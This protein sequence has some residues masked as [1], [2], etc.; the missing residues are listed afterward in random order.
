MSKSKPQTI[1]D[2]KINWT[3]DWNI[4]SLI[5]AKIEEANPEIKHLKIVKNKYNFVINEWDFTVQ[6]IDNDTLSSLL[7][8][9]DGKVFPLQEINQLP[10]VLVL[11]HCELIAENTFRIHVK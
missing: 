9:I 10:R 1:A 11:D 6:T 7:W 2:L 5:L 8:K 4:E 3:F